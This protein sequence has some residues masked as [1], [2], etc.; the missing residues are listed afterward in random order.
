M[1]S[2]LLTI[3]IG[4]FLLAGCQSANSLSSKL[5]SGLFGP[6]K[7]KHTLSS[8][9]PNPSS[10]SAMQLSSD[11][12]REGE[13]ALKNGNLKKAKRSFLAVVK[14]QPS[15]AAA[16]HRLGY[17]ADKMEDF[18]MSRIHYITA[19]KLEPNNPD[20]ACD[21]GYSYLLQNQL[22]ESQR[23]L[24]KALTIDPNH[25]ASLLNMASLLGKRGN[26]EGALAIF[27]QAGSEQEAQENIAQLFPNGRPVDQAMASGNN[28]QKQPN[29]VTQDLQQQMADLANKQRAEMMARKKKMDAAREKLT[30]R[31]VPAGDINDIF[32]KIDREFDQ[33]Q[34]GLPQAIPGSRETIP[35]QSLPTTQPNRDDLIAQ[36]SHQHKTPIEYKP[37]A[38]PPVLP[39]SSRNS[40]VPVEIPT[41]S[42][43]DSFEDYA[44]LRSEPSITPPVNN[45]STTHDAGTNST[46]LLASG[47]QNN[48]TGQAATSYPQSVSEPSSPASNQIPAKMQPQQNQT[49]QFALNNQIP[50]SQ[51]PSNQVPNSQAMQSPASEAPADAASYQQAVK[52]AMQMGMNAGPGQMFPLN[53]KQSSNTKQPSAR[54]QAYPSGRNYLTGPSSTNPVLSRQPAPPVKKKHQHPFQHLP[55][56]SP[57]TPSSR[58]NLP[59]VAQHENHH[60]AAP[61]EN[62][63]LF[64]T[65]Q[66]PSPAMTSAPPT[67]TSTQPVRR[68]GEIQNWPYAP[69]SQ[70]QQASHEHL[71]NATGNIHQTKS[72][73]PWFNQQENQHQ[74]NRQY[75]RNGKTGNQ[76]Q[77]PLMQPSA[78]GQNSPSQWPYSPQTGNPS[79]QNN[80]PVIHR[81]TQYPTPYSNRTNNVNSSMPQVVPGAR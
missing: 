21:L 20:I 71:P 45:H 5:T 14:Q 75:S 30:P 8:N 52:L 12:F 34:Q 19:M 40:S 41:Q 49:P 16:H 70:V 38:G 65:S 35:S 7:S 13:E 47:V 53:T 79:P 80:G 78:R 28:Q 63:P 68:G 22:E 55:I 29:Q 9:S 2:S 4:C 81:R 17:I 24:E 60:H 48:L 26:Y 23:Y 11:D 56:Q 43:P 74:A 31:E 33:K 76:N 46:A 36:N 15:N 64:S 59:P 18:T 69:N 50:S 6:S 54:S 58:P 62:K 42:I 61:T 66:T 77:L 32:A 67:S 37:S 72:E 73:T 44:I 1:K 3:I 27:R 10:P 39:A 51:I 25:Q 57:T